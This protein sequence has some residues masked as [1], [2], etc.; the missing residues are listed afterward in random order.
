MALLP[1][2]HGNF[3]LPLICIDARIAHILDELGC[4]PFRP[5][6]GALL[7]HLLSKFYERISII[8][9]TNVSPTMGFLCRMVRTSGLTAKI[10]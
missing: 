4:L 10:Q 7:F 1:P 9:T 2:Q 3:C 6:D 5:S 8:I